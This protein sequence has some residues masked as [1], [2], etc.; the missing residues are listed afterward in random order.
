[1]RGVLK[2]DRGLC[3]FVCPRVCVCARMCVSTCVSVSVCVR[4][5][6]YLCACVCVPGL[7]E[8]TA[9]NVELKR[10]PCCV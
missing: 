1:M 8:E 3:V 6:V 9:D 10:S 2:T 4:A 5:C 7:Q